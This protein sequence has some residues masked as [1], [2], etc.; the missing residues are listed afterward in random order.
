MLVV[1][2][3]PDFIQMRQDWLGKVGFVPTMGNLHAGHESLLR[4]SVAENDITVLSIYVNPTQ[5][6]QSQDYQAYPMTLQ[7]DLEV[8]K[9]SGVDVVLLPTY[10]Q[11]YTQGYRYQVVENQ[12]SLEMEGCRSG[13]F[14][15]VLTVVMK[16]FNVVR[17]DRA[18]FGEKDYQQYLLIK[19][20]VAAFF[21]PIEIVSCETVRHVSGL[22][23]SSR[24][25]RLSQE[26]QVRAAQLFDRL[27]HGA[28]ASL[29]KSQ[30]ESLGMDVDYVEDRQ[31][32]RYA[33]VV[34][35]GVR[36]IDNVKIM[37]T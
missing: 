25:Q 20:M 22:A 13:H 37:E 29:I 23:M 9:S 35:D 14:N 12:L 11:I 19:D 7:Q 26:A 33:A 24:N 10:E 31:G 15:G 8:A 2:S 27:T 5:F 17:P 28:S 34:I 21:L 4:R 36:L 32:R 3:I 1:E 18:Y 30:L 16:L 6:D